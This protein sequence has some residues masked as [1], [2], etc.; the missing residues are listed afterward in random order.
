MTLPRTSALL[1]LFCALWL[2]LQAAVV[3]SAACGPACDADAAMGC[4]SIERPAP[5]TGSCCGDPVQPEP[6]PCRCFLEDDGQPWLPQRDGVDTAETGLTVELAPEGE[7]V[8]LAPGAAW[9]APV[10]GRAGAGP[11]LH[12]RH[13]V[14][15]I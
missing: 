15:L 2:P 13:C 7:A 1:L 8:W 10:R 12:V 9:R 11:P 14:W 4:C 6:A 3:R 5:P